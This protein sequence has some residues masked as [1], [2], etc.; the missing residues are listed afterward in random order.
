MTAKKFN[1]E[2]LPLISTIEGAE[3]TGTDQVDVTTSG[4]DALLPARMPLIKMVPPKHAED[5]DF[6]ATPVGT[7]AYMWE[8][9]AGTEP[10]VLTRNKDYWGAEAGLPAGEIEEVTVRAIPD[11]S[12][13]LAALKADE[14]DMITVLPPDAAKDVPKVGE[15]VGPENPLVILNTTSGITADP[16]V[17]QALNLAVDKEALADQLF[18]GYAEV[19]K[20]QPVSPLATGYNDQLQPYP[21]DPEKAKELISQAGAA[22]KDLTLV[23]SDVFTN[24]R[25]LAQTLAA[26]WTDA[27]L[28]VDVKIP[29]FD[30]YLE[31]LYAKGESRPDAVYVSTSTDL[32]D[33]GSAARQLTTDGNQSAYSNPTVDDL[34]KQGAETDDVNERAGIYQRALDIACKDAAL[35]NLLNPKDLYGMAERLNWQPRSDGGVYFQDMSLGSDGG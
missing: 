11:V 31:D 30:S 12:T 15:T 17:R 27:G 34:F 22:G 24:G 35:V 8:S 5:K 3:A 16:R 20:C 28:K 23:G 32:L 6:A 14:V 25:E 33:A 18:A 9:G 4:P 19:S 7:G 29:G 26:F 21:Y 2:L 10:I 1:A 13:R